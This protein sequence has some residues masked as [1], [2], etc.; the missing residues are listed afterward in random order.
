MRPKFKQLILTILFIV[1]AITSAYSSTSL[2][3]VPKPSKESTTGKQILVQKKWN[4]F[5][6][7]HFDISSEYLNFLFSE[8]GIEIVNSKKDKAQISVTEDNKKLKDPEAYYLEVTGKGKINIS[9]ITKNGV[10]YAFQTLTQIV[11]SD[12][13]IITL[14]VCKITDEPA[15]AWRTFMLDDSRHFQGMGMVKR[16][17]DEM[18]RLKMNTFHWHLVDDFGWRIEI[19]KYPELTEIGSKRDYTRRELSYE[20]CNEKFPDQKMYYTQDEIREIVKYAADK[21]IKIMP[22]IEVPGHIMP[23]Q[24]T[25]LHHHSISNGIHSP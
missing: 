2:P 18:S 17:L 15:F 24:G 21:G 1:L 6:P 14:P 5:I 7:T 8:F 20:E 25:I 12:N 16:L 13:N 3:I 9:A 11:Q 19:R 4:V 10:L 22:E 23:I